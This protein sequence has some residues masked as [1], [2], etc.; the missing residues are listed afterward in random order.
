MN[1]S[2]LRAIAIGVLGRRFRMRHR[3]KAP[4]ES[5]WL[6]ISNLLGVTSPPSHTPRPNFPGVFSDGEGICDPVVAL[7]MGLIVQFA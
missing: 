3:D 4:F 1:E 5:H 2:L 7:R 6:L